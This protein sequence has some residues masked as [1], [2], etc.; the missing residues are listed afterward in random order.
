[1]DQLSTQFGSQADVIS[2]GSLVILCHATPMAQLFQI[3]FPD[4]V[5]LYPTE[6]FPVNFNRCPVNVTLST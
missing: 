4:L 1:M 3:L 6:T 2:N 5:G